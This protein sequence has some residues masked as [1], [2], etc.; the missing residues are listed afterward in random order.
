MASFALEFSDQVTNTDISTSFTVTNDDNTVLFAGVHSIDGVPADV[1]SR[2][3]YGNKLFQLVGAQF[4]DGAADSRVELWVLIDPESGSNTFEY[5]QSILDFTG[6][7]IV[8]SVTGIDYE[9]PFNGVGSTRLNNSSTPPAG[10]ATKNDTVDSIGI[11][12]VALSGDSTPGTASATTD[13]TL[14]ADEDAASNTEGALGVAYR[15]M[16]SGINSISAAVEWSSTGAN[17]DWGVVNGIIR[18]GSGYPRPDDFEPDG[19]IFSY[20]Q[21]NLINDV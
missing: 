2:M 3:S 7:I 16:T 11:S 21:V 20:P 4:K 15:E 5:S 19:D 6:Q 12:V 1:V 13:H 10:S 9:T 14:L 8:G 17:T 18:V